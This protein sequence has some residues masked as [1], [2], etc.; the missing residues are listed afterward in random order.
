[1]KTQE[2]ILVSFLAL[3]SNITLKLFKILMAASKRT[4]VSNDTQIMWHAAFFID[5]FYYSP[6]KLVHT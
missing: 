5:H 4:D 1:M 3:S 6:S 2:H